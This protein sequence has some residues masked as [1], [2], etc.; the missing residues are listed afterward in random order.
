MLKVDKTEDISSF[1]E[2]LM[3]WCKRMNNQEEALVWRLRTGNENHLQCS[4]T[5]TDTTRSCLDSKFY[6]FSLVA[7]R[8]KIS[9]CGSGRN[10]LRC[11]LKAT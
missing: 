6:T 11:F 10:R 4:G 3:V 5:Q 8:L 1:I 2:E 9:Y 7:L